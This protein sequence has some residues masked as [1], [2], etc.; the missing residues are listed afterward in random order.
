M[1]A[2]GVCEFTDTTDAEKDATN[3]V[4]QFFVD[5]I[6]KHE[7]GYYIRLLIRTIIRRCHLIGRLRLNDDF[8]R[9]NV[10]ETARSTLRFNI[11]GVERQGHHREVPNC[12][13]PED[14]I[15][16]YIQNQPLLHLRRRLLNCA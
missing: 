14:T 9:E 5:T 15:V 3:K 13:S 16:Q 1:H 6:E 2:A 10:E 12:A 4:T 8:A 11:S 7:D